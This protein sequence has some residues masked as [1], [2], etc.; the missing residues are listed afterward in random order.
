MSLQYHPNEIHFTYLYV[1]CKKISKIQEVADLQKASAEGGNKEMVE[2]NIVPNAEPVIEAVVPAVVEPVVPV[3]EVPVVAPAEVVVAEVVE[4]PVVA[5]VV[6]ASVEVVP[7]IEAAAEV[8]PKKTDEEI[9]KMEMDLCKAVKKGQQNK[10]YF[11][12]AMMKLREMKKSSKLHKASVDE[13]EVAKVSLAT[14]TLGNEE[15]KAKIQ[16][17]ETSAVKILERKNA[18][19]EFG[20]DL[21]EKDILDD[22]KFELSKVKKENAELKSKLETSS[23]HVA[24]KPALVVGD[25]V[26]ARAK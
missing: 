1:C 6:E 25:E 5:A 4:A 22:D 3:A 2:E 18:L 23:A 13:L 24:V 26:K 11:K 16:L 10:D 19:G 12:K 8:K 15:L 21:S 17:L 9:E 14:L 7:V 20:K